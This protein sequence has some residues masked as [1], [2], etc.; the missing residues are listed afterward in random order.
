MKEQRNNKLKKFL[1]I[2]ALF[3]AF[4]L[5]IAITYSWTA[6]S[7]QGKVSGK[8]F[9]VV[10]G[11]DIYATQDDKRIDSISGNDITLAEVSSV[12]GRN[13]FFPLENNTS[14]D[15]KLMKFREG[16][17]ADINTNY[18]QCDFKLT[19]LKDNLPV[20]LDVDITSSSSYA[21]TPIRVSIN[22]NNATTP[23]VL[24][25]SATSFAAISSISN[26]GS[27]VATESTETVSFA[28]YKDRNKPLFTF[29]K[30]GDVKNIT[31]TIWLEGTAINS[32]YTSAIANYPIDARIKFFT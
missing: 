15:T 1:S 32:M 9:E 5:I 26:D 7:R 13:F 14:N 10:V 19:A 16:T 28:E 22:Y 3:E 31:V 29:N 20:Y 6:G 8:E 23:T 2:M 25:D 12:D 17:S 4:V 30:N 24:S 27:M 18:F 11:G 21:V